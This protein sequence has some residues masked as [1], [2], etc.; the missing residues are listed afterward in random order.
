AGAL[1]ARQAGFLAEAGAL[2]TCADLSAHASTWTRPI[3]LPYRN[4]LA[5][6]HPPNSS[7]VI[8][9]VA[10]AILD[11]FAAPR[12]EFDADRIHTAVEASR[13]ALGDRERELAE[14]E[15]MAPGAIE[16]LLDPAHAAE[17]ATRID[18]RRS[19]TGTQST[20]PRG[21]GTVF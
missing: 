15:A 8:A 5:T 14:P 16:R 13:L 10:L 2:I 1:G 3:G 4:A 12:D 18:P 7:G 17:L 19:G 20:V 11:R 9:L 6:T 21:G